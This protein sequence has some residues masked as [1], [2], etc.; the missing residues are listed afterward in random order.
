MKIGKFLAGVAGAAL[1]FAAGGP[2]GA[3]AGFGIAGG[4]AGERSERKAA[5][6]EAQ[7]QQN[8]YREQQDVIRRESQR[9]NSQLEA[10]RNKVAQGIARASRSRIRGGIFGEQNPVGQLNQR[11][12]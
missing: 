3:A 1:G 5:K 2:A 12:G 11:L 4:I 8:A 6:R 7:N 9:I 10:S